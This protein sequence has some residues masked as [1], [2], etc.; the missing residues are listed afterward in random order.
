MFR[1]LF[2]VLLLIQSANAFLSTE[3]NYREQA[4]VLK[5]LDI[6]PTFLTDLLFITMKEDA[7]KYRTKH[8]LKV[9]EN[10]NRFIPVLQ[11]MLKEAGVPDAF[12]YLAMAESNFVPNAYSRARAV[13]IWQFMPYTGRKFGL[14][15]NL[16]VDERRDPIKST[17]AAIKY[18]KYL[19][20][21]FGKWY[22]AAIAYNCGEGRVSKAIRRAGTDDLAVLLEKDKKYIPRESR[23]Y[24]RKIMMMEHLSTSTDFIVGH[25]AG[26]LMNRGTTHT[27][28]K[29]NVKGGTTLDNV[30]D[31]IGMSYKEL[32]SYN[33][34][35][36][37]GFV[38]P[39]K[40]KYHIYLP[41]GKQT[42]F[43]QNYDPKKDTGRFYVH[44]I[45]KGDSLYYIGK[46]YGVSYKVIKDFNR[47]KSNMLS[48]NKKLI[49]PVL[50]PKTRNYTIRNG[51]T[52]KRISRKFDVAIGTIMKVNNKKS[53]TIKVGERLVIPY[54]Y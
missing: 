36:R 26:Y 25:N 37:Y 9:L 21:R 12:L 32:K 15:I 39:R 24:I 53:S 17:E 4:K 22:L 49:I 20:E 42:L 41:Y 47:L 18:L 13:G 8:F 14:D 2:L 29:V 34:H 45:K 6:D 40:G 46:K 48:L 3:T 52:M 28:A 33:P 38:P 43:E 30:A 31:S 54:V 51:D 16:Y 7:D 10:G 1:F 27:F 44:Q 11:N 23:I 35:L 50:K 19:H 5:S